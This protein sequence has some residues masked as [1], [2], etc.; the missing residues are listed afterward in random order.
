MR[1]SIKYLTTNLEISRYCLIS[2]TTLMKF[3]MYSDVSL[4]RQTV[5]GGI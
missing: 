3:I 4:Y 5:G 1:K 2:V